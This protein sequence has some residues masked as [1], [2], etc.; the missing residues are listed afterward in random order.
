MLRVH[1]I[2]TYNSIIDSFP[3][4]QNFMYAS[5]FQLNQN[6]ER[7]DFAKFT[8]INKKQTNQKKTTLNSL[9]FDLTNGL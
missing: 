3:S 8:A 4:M 1:T 5:P 2:C 7:F 9:R 6:G